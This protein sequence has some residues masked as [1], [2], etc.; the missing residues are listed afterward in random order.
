MIQSFSTCS[1]NGRVLE[2]SNIYGMNRKIYS[3][4]SIIKI[5]F[6]I[7]PSKIAR[8]I[9][10]DHSIIRDCIWNLVQYLSLI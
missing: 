5:G 9:G 8:P 7:L 6:E 1:K 3:P 2:V 4:D 10:L